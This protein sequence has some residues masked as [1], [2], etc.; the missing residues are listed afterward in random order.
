MA[1]STKEMGRLLAKDLDEI[2][3]SID[4]ERRTTWAIYTEFNHKDWRYDIIDI[5]PW[6]DRYSSDDL[7]PF[8]FKIEGAI[9][10]M[11]AY[12]KFVEGHK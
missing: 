5:V 6:A 8:T 11:A 2:F 3:R 9:D 1:I 10:E 7:T 4:D 12:K